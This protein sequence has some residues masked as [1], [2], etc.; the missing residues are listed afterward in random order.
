MRKILVVDDEKI[1]LM[2]AQRILSKKYDV[3]C[4][5]SGAEAL[6]IFEKV[7]PD[8]ILSDL[9]MPEMDGYELH[10]RLQEKSAETVPIIF[11]TA[12]DSDESE[13]KGFEV[14]AMDYIRKPLKADLLLR[15][16][17]KALENLD[18]IHGL[19]AAA[20][21][22]MM[23]GLLNKSAIQTEIGGMI[24]KNPGALLMMDL[25]SFKL[26]ND[27]Y[28]HGMGDKILVKF[29]ELIKNILSESDKAGRLGGD[30]FV[31]YL[32]GISEE[33]IL[34]EKSDYLNVEI[35][36]AAK[37]LFGENFNVSLG[38]SVGAVFSPKEGTEFAALYKK[39]DSALYK[40]KQRGKH[41]LMIYGGEQTAEEHSAG[42]EPSNIR[43]VLDERNNPSGAYFVD[44]ETF[45]SIYRLTARVADVY[46][47]E[48]GLIEVEFPIDAS[49][50][51]CKDKI[52]HALQRSDCVTKSGK[53]KFLILLPETKQEDAESVKI[54]LEKELGIRS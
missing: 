43:M 34:Q 27:I 44:F 38:V 49:A 47:K 24:E 14:G 35:L 1:M 30:E 51:D 17:D 15:R 4:A 21:I 52:R 31:A 23:T 19:K 16:V 13:S 33:K 42:E 45:K 50:D 26:V 41:G 37:K 53:N 9:M 40:V 2:L 5:K 20:T 10:D 3:V 48:L 32:K 29:S 54:K 6:E 46:K 25:D 39:A 7:N 12:D 18:K 36:K 22:D 11:M 28:G 8:L